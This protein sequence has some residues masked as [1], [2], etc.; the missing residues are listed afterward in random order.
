[1]P[2]FAKV[3]SSLARGFRFPC[4]ILQAFHQPTQ[5]KGCLLYTSI[6]PGLIL[7]RAP[8]CIAARPLEEP[9]YRT[10]G[11][12]LRSRE[13]ASLATQRFLEYLDCR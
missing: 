7:R 3:R 9:A 4:R 12:A 11:L 5:V 13:A 2:R 6:L 10:I 8:Y 1:M